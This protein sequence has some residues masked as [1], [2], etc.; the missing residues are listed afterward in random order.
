MVK[1]RAKESWIA[2]RDVVVP[3]EEISVGDIVEFF[4]ARWSRSG[5]GPGLRFGIVTRIE[6][7]LRRVR[8]ESRVVAEGVEP[9]VA[10]KD[11]IWEAQIV[12]N[13]GPRGEGE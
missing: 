8:V 2:E 11:R 4:G 1:G 6:P 3:V 13:H 9:Y 12:A 5:S 7:T 10:W